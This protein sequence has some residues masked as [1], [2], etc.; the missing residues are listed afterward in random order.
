[1][2]NALIKAATFLDSSVLGYSS[3]IAEKFA[4][5][6]PLNTF[7]FPFKKYTYTAVACTK[8]AAIP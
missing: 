2:I 1:L 6:L 4:S 8:V 3:I 5:A 7:N